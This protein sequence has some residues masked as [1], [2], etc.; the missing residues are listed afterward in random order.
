MQPARKLETCS[1]GIHT[2]TACT[3]C[4][5]LVC[6]HCSSQEITTHDPKNITITFYCPECKE[7]PKKNPW[8]TLY[9]ENLSA[10]YN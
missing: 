6:R 9:W 7:N 4:G 3:G 5:T 8:G 10:L 2:E 1:C